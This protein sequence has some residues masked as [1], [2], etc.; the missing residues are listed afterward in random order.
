[1]ALNVSQL[2]AKNKLSSFCTTLTTARTQN[3]KL[4][5]LK[6]SF[7]TVHFNLMLT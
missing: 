5:C 1:M 3:Q 6:T 7:S 2:V 4:I